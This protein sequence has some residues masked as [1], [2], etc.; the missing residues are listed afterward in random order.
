M[1]VK[2][3]L[4]KSVKILQ[5]LQKRN[6]KGFELENVQI[7]CQDVTEGIDEENL[8]LSIFRPSKTMGC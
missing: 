2:F 6:I 1:K 5:K 7:K 8:D 3:I 4:T